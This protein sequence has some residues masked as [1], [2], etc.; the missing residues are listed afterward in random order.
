MACLVDEIEF[1]CNQLFHPIQL[2]LLQEV[3]H[4]GELG[5][6]EDAGQHLQNELLLRCVVK[7]LI[8]KDLLVEGFADQK[9]QLTVD[10]TRKKSIVVALLDQPHVGVPL[11]RVAALVLH[12]LL[13]LLLVAGRRQVFCLAELERLPHYFFVEADAL[14]GGGCQWEPHHR[15]LLVKVHL[16][17]SIVN[18]DGAR[19]CGHEVGA[20]DHLAE[21]CVV[22]VLQTRLLL[23]AIHVHSLALL[24]YFIGNLATAMLRR[25]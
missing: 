22:H 24:I 23:C 2:S 13:E 19:L 12:E 16:L 15:C 21:A 3:Q 18:V 5:A 6:A 11:H 7:C 8:P 4:E 20:K 9:E 1:L 14:A 25:E 10:L 17:L